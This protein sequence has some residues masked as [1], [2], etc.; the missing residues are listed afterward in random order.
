[1]VKPRTF[2]IELRDGA[3]F[4]ATESFGNPKVFEYHKFRALRDEEVPT[5]HD[6]IVHTYR[7]YKNK[8]GSPWF[9][10]W[11]EMSDTQRSDRRKHF[12]DYTP[13]L[14]STDNIPHFTGLWVTTDKWCRMF[15]D[16]NYYTIVAELLDN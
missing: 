1:M 5:H 4:V 13:I 14:E 8:D 3:F 7:E 12:Q 11:S 9:K 10:P 6:K 16:P 15:N 2:V